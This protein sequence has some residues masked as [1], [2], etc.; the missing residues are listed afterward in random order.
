M[1][2]MILITI[3]IINDTLVESNETVN[4]TL[5]NPTNGAQLGGTNPVALTITDNDS[6]GGGSGSGSGNNTLNAGGDSVSGGGCGF[7]KG[8]DNGKGPGA[9]GG[10]AAFAMMLIIT[11]AGIAIARKISLLKNSI[12]FKTF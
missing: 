9:K 8:D 10:A 4:I 2:I 11:L 12:P 3:T 7:V 6:A 5:S 1:I